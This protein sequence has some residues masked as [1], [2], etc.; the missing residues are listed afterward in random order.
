MGDEEARRRSI[1]PNS[2]APNP[3][4]EQEGPQIVSLFVGLNYSYSHTWC[5]FMVPK[6]INS[7]L[8]CMLKNNCWIYLNAKCSLVWKWKE[9]W[10]NKEFGH[11][12]FLALV[13]LRWK[14]WDLNSV[15]GKLVE[16]E[17]FEFEDSEIPEKTLCRLI[18]SIKFWQDFKMACKYFLGVLLEKKRT[19]LVKGP[20]TFPQYLPLSVT[21]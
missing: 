6:W 21:D 14:I 20:Q 15:I 7:Y 16:L 2:D 18:H 11:Q 3:D 5:K 4:G 19:K 13:E 1:T 12:I 9:F 17:Q 8:M 10:Y